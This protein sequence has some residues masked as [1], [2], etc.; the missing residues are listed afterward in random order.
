MV[1][2]VIS[3]EENDKAWL[4]RKAREQGVTMTELVRQAI[5]HFRMKGGKNRTDK[6]AQPTFEEI[7]ERVSGT[8][9]QGD[10]AEYVRKM[11]E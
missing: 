4:D 8:W 11:R 10:A 6:N 7:M 5:R 2:T 1:R 9:T 3:L